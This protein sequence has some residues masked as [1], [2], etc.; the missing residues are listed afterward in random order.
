[1]C[2]TIKILFAKRVENGTYTINIHLLGNFGRLHKSLPCT[3][4]KKKKQINILSST[5]LFH[6]QIHRHVKLDSYLSG[7]RRFAMAVGR[8]RFLLLL[9]FE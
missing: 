3:N 5:G 4:Q 2:K 7:D 8:N 9:T 1:M 6:K